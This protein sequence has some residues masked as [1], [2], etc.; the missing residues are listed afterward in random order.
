[1]A[2]KGMN[3][4]LEGKGIELDFSAWREELDGETMKYPLTYKTFGEAIPPQYA[5]QVLD[6]LTNSNAIISTGVGQHQKWAA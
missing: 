3:G 1:M 4:L 5:I 6:E 2:M